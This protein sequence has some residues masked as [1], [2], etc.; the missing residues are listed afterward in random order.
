MIF[1]GI[2][3]KFHLPTLV[4]SKHCTHQ[5]DRKRGARA[6]TGNSAIATSG[7]VFVPLTDANPMWGVLRPSL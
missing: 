6:M 2:Q 4:Q 1:F 3:G 5:D 7:T